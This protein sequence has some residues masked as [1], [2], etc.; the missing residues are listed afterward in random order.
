LAVGKAAV[1]NFIVDVKVLLSGIV[2]DSED[3]AW[4]DS[5]VNQEASLDTVERRHE[6]S[7]E[8]LRVRNV[9]PLENRK[10]DLVLGLAEAVTGLSRP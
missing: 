1:D 7:E 2:L 10:Q 8:R 6:D 5:V 9:Q 4:R 3:V